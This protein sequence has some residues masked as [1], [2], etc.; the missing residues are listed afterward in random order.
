MPEGGAVISTGGEEPKENKELDRA[1]NLQDHKP[2]DKETVEIIEKKESQDTAELHSIKGP[3]KYKPEDET[4]ECEEE[5]IQATDI[6]QKIKDKSKKASREVIT[7]EVQ[8]ITEKETTE[9]PQIRFCPDCG[10]EL[11][12][13]A[14]FCTKC[15]CKVKT[16]GEDNSETQ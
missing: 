9:F 5:K 6:E 14:I 13:D 15:G 3:E 12:E 8:D 16:D 10:S 2:V 1:E 7:E 4:I 11:E